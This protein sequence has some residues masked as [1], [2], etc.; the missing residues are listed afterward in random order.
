MF[1][2]KI[3]VIMTTI[4][5]TPDTGLVSLCILAAV[6][7]INHQGRYYHSHLTDEETD[8]HFILHDRGP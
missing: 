7:T 6:Y 1:Y 4:S 3:T 2:V 5:Y 8:A